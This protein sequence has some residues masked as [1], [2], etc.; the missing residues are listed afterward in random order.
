MRDRVGVVGETVGLVRPA[1]FFT[2]AHVLHH[3]Q[4]G[5]GVVP[6]HVLTGVVADQDLVAVGVLHQGRVAR[7]RVLFA[8][9]RGAPHHP[10]AAVREPEPVGHAII[11]Q[12]NA[13]LGRPGLL[14]LVGDVQAV[15][16]AG[17]VPE[18]VVVNGIGSDVGLHPLFAPS[19][20]SFGS[21]IPSI[22]SLAESLNSFGA[23]TTRPRGGSVSSTRKAAGVR[24]R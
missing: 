13:L 4:A 8:A 9:G 5:A 22:R 15:L 10:E 20:R 18:R 21:P 19:R 17:R 11:G 14:G 3:L 16:R 12:V 24:S 6:K 23:K 7:T 1:G 2:G